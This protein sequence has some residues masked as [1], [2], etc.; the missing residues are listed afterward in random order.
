V[1]VLKEKLLS[2]MVFVGT[3]LVMSTDLG[4][5][6]KPRLGIS[7]EQGGAASESWELDLSSPD[8]QYGTRLAVSWLQLMRLVP[9]IEEKAEVVSGILCHSLCVSPIVVVWAIQPA[10]AS[11]TQN[12]P[13]RSLP[14]ADGIGETCVYE[15]ELESQACR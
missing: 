12:D 6:A 9:A 3:L 4:G 8:S 5:L 11:Q 7:H 1:P 13:Y 2:K 15:A 10:G 14:F